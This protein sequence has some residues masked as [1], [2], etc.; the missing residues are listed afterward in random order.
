MIRAIFVVFLIGL[1]VLLFVNRAD[2][3]LG[4]DA[5]GYASLARMLDVI[6][7]GCVT[8]APTSWS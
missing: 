3:I 1:A 5:T 4:A 2:S 8:G 6:W 7:A